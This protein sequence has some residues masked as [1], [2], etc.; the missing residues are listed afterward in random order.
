MFPLYAMGMIG[1]SLSPLFPVGGIVPL[2]NLFNLWVGNFFPYVAPHQKG[3]V[4]AC[5]IQLDGGER[6][7]LRWP[8]LPETGTSPLADLL[9]DGICI[10]DAGGRVR[11]INRALEEFFGIGRDEVESMPIADFLVQ[12]VSPALIEPQGGIPKDFLSPSPTPP[13][14]L[15]EIRI[16]SH[17]EG[18]LWVE[19]SGRPFP[20]EDGRVWRMDLF[21]RI[22]RWKVAEHHFMESEERYR[23]L[24]NKGNDA[25]L[26]FSL[27][28]DRVPERF[29]EVNDIACS[30]FG[31]TRQELLELSPLS[32]VPSDMIGA[33]F[34]ILKRLSTDRSVVYTSRQITKGGLIIPV[35]INSSLFSMDGEQVVISISRDISERERLES[36]K[37]NALQQIGHNI[38]QF[39][40][41]G[42]HIRNP[43]AVIVGLASLEETASSI[44]ILEAAGLIDALVTE[45]DRGWIESENVR[46]FLRKHYG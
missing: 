38:E 34:R 26:V 6:T 31:Y 16:A 13:S 32:L 11:W 46:A 20:G 4:R 36:L 2:K 7:P 43:L 29:L 17:R 15:L 9:D 8:L 12:V 18:P 24:F 5:G 37:K 44:Q 23:L 3:A 22:N 35:E 45:L 33:V 28:A 21:R 27:S 10:I 39:A 30:R 42:D 14:G 19:Y 41:L 25:V 40:T 1:F